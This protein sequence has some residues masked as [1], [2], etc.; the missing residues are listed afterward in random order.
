MNR[1]V[2]I[3]LFVFS[4]IKIQSQNIT[5]NDTFT[6]NELVEQFLINNP[7]AN[8][9][10]IQASGFEFG[11]GDKSYGYFNKNSSI[12]PFDEGVIITNGRA[13]S[14]IGPNITLLSEG[15]N[16]WLG[17][18]DLEIAINE[19][20][21]FNA[22]VLSFDFL[23]STNKISFE[24]IFSSEQYLAYANPNQCRFSDGFAFLLKEANSTQPYQNLA[25]VPGTNTPVK[26]TSVRGS[27]TICDPMNEQ[28]FDA[29]NGTQHPTNYNGQT[30]IL[31][32]VSNVI[33][34]VLYHIKLVIADQGNPLYDSAIFLG[35]GT[36]EVGIDLGEDLLIA[37]QNALCNGST[38]PLN[39]TTPNA[40]SYQWFKDGVAINNPN[41]NPAIFD[42]EDNGFYEVETQITGTT[43]TL[44]GS[45]TIEYYPAPDLNLVNYSNCG[46]NNQSIF[47]LNHVFES[48]IATTS[49]SSVSYH[50]TFDD[51]ENNQN[52]LS[53][54]ENFIA[55][56]NTPVFIRFRDNVTGC[57]YFQQAML[58]VNNI[59]EQILPFQ[60]CD[61][62]ALKDGIT[63][64]DLE[65]EISSIII[66]N[67]TSNHQI[68]YFTNF[69]DAM[70][71]NNP[72]PNNFTNTTAFNQSIF[73]KVSLNNNCEEIIRVDL[74]IE[75][76]V[77]DNSIISEFLCPT[78]TVRLSAPISSQ[79]IYLW[80]TGQTTASINVSNVGNYQVD[81]TNN[82]GCSNS[83]NFLVDNIET[84]EIIN[85]EQSNFLNN[86]YININTIGNNNLLFSIDGVNFQSSSTFNNL[87]S[88][89]YEIIVKDIFECLIRTKR[90]VILDY[91]RFFTPNGDGMNDSW[92]IKNLPSNARILIFDK[93]G[94]MIA[95]L[96]Y[97]ETWQGIYNNRKLPSADYWF[98]LEIDEKTIFKNHF[99][100]KR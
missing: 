70:S 45:V 1:F 49:Q 74:N 85:V 40:T 56:N 66:L 44:R 52:E 18:S 100:L 15:P 73:A 2:L 21:T 17:D 39:A 30:K 16:S 24:Y 79:F 10:N 59:S 29:F 11:N 38:Y 55:T 33:P 53:N 80:S 19:S 12:F 75:A 8:V 94:K 88:G 27:G 35:G 67:Y 71:G 5:I 69:N 26:V 91:P 97:N 13:K 50:L 65:S 57:I 90:I 20:N 54:Y 64:T 7:C 32:A 82:N 72:L 3:V 84:F 36:F 63:N 99:S 93:Y 14:A 51:A 76:I 96:K 62:D 98:T 23:P 61:E 89:I 81:I 25:V 78:G 6:A 58:I 4:F 37:N 60:K 34:G 42:V 46:A 41:P 86:N 47:N 9:S 83:I 68:N 43:C 95:N 77:I 92:S 22:T 87:Q 31:K 48:L 28:Y